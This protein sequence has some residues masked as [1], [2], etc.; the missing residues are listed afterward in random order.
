MRGTQWKKKKKEKT[1]KKKKEKTNNRTIILTQATKGS[2][3]IKTAPQKYT[4]QMFLPNPWSQRNL[5]KMENQI[6]F[7]NRLP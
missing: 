1:N 6:L 5:S 3:H 2:S 7:L 4:R